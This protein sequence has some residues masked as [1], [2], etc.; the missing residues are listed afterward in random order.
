MSASKDRKPNT[1]CE[2]GLALF[3]CCAADSRGRVHDEPEHRYRSPAMR[4]RD[5][6]VHSTAFRRLEYKTQ[7]FV[8]H[9]GDYYR[10]RLTHTMEVAQIARIMAR[11]LLVNEDLT[12]AI[13]L[14]HDIGHT[15]FGHSGE[16]ALNELMATEGGFE[17]NRHGLRVVDV[18]ERRYPDF[19]GLNLTWEVREGIIKHRTTHDRPASNSEFEPDRFPTVEAQIVDVADII[20][21]DSHDVD[22][23]LKSGLILADD[24]GK[25]ELWKRAVSK[26][27]ERYGE[28]PAELGR[29]QAVRFL[30]DMEVS[31]ALSESARRIEKR[32]PKSVD[33]VRKA[34]ERLVALS[35]K[36][37]RTKREMEDFLMERLYHHH[38]VV[39]MSNKA[40]RFVRSIFNAYTEDYRQLPPDYQQRVR[41]LRDELTVGTEVGEEQRQEIQKCATRRIV[42]DYIAGMTDR[43]ALDEYLKLYTPY[44]RV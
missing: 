24:I 19:Q 35:E 44:E 13:A 33:D 3:A 39:R 31:D 6:I 9:E 38:R 36:M 29:V 42:C 10:T 20:A 2:R 43:F 16:E 14:A 12:E 34:P 40:K 37:T 4:D 18:L 32:D 1:P 8:N 17:H 11:A 23:G 22:D 21:Y 26:V 5:R 41:Q 27:H 28:V 30:I 15:P 7:V 25:I